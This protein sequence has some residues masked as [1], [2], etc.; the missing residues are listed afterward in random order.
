MSP[1]AAASLSFSDLRTLAAA[2]L[3]AV[4][5]SWRVKS[6]ER[7]RTAGLGG[8]LLLWMLQPVLHLSITA[9]I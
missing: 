1:S 8:Y 6:V 7:L 2:E 9:L 4:A 5:A 3:R